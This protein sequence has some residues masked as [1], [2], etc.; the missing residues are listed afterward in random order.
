MQFEEFDNKIR[1]AADHHHPAYDENAW[2]RMEKLLNKHLPQENDGRRRI[3]FFLLLF[4]LLG[5]GSVWLF[6]S[7]PW[8]RNKQVT[9][10]KTG[11]QKST[12]EPSTPVSSNT[13]DPHADNNKLNK[14][15]VAGI[16]VPGNSKT[17]TEPLP[18]DQTT[19]LLNS[20]NK[21]DRQTNMLVT[22]G[23]S[24][25]NKKIKTD[26]PALSFN[27]NPGPADKNIKKDRLDQGQVDA[28][29]TNSTVATIIPGQKNNKKDVV[30]DKNLTITTNTKPVVNDPSGKENTN[31]DNTSLVQNSPVKKA[32]DKNKKTNTFFF[33]LSAGP[34]I[35]ATGGDQLGKAKLLTGAGLGYTFKDRLTIRSGFY[36]G[37]K[38]YTSSPGSYHPPAAFWSYYPNLQKVD[39]DCRVYEIPLSLSY[40]FSHSSKQQLFASAGIS[41]LLM[42]SEAYDY[43]YKYTASGPTVTRKYTIKD[44]NKHYF[45]ILTLSGGYQKNIGKSLSVTVE[46]YLKLPLSG[47]GFGNV[48]LNSGGIL[49]SV[50]IKPFAGSGKHSNIHR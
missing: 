37:R 43:Y 6:S 48:K 23:V 25:K 16:N 27:N 30:E 4:L 18:P 26:Q 9:A 2:A 24:N 40:N 15:E 17:T 22:T 3:I 32:K 50:G 31:K 7:K 41:S 13:Q 5:G 19:V 47:I 38:I 28:A 46:P 8:N 14:E 44:Q 11:I 49:F 12:G 36:S 10:T 29:T 35:S 34:D 42:K 39:A 21:K 45:S 20:V 1:E 33:T